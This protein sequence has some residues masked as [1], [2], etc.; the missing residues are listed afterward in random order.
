MHVRA[1]EG[2][3]V[4]NLQWFYGRVSVPLQVGEKWAIRAAIC[5]LGYGRDFMLLSLIVKNNEASII[6][7][8]LE[9]PSRASC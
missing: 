2:T 8:I 9:L 3:A 1:A 6:E 7:I 5:R 4:V